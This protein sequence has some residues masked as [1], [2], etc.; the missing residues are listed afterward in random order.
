MKILGKRNAKNKKEI[1]RQAR[2]QSN[3]KKISAR[4]QFLL[5]IGRVHWRE[6]QQDKTQAAG[7][8]RSVKTWRLPAENAEKTLAAG[9]SLDL[10]KK[11]HPCSQ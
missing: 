9:K 2:R 4:E 11:L 3:K 7:M 1:E 8:Y 10:S 5:V 6:K